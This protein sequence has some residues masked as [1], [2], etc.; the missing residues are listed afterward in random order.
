MK[1][2]I[3]GT[4]VSDHIYYYLLAFNDRTDWEFIRKK[5]GKT[6]LHDLTLYEYTELFNHAFKID[7]KKLS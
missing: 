2:L 1:T 5:F 7:I 6:R 4:E 3:D